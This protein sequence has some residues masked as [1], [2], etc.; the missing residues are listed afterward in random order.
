MC[1]EELIDLIMIMITFTIS[2]YGEESNKCNSLSLSGFKCTKFGSTSSF[3]L[4]RD[5]LRHSSAR[6]NHVNICKDK[7]SASALD[8]YNL[9]IVQQT[10]I[11][12]ALLI[13]NWHHISKDE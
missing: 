7:L 12:K 9:V 2:I 10:I 4:C 6:Q 1:G 3:Y 13:H 11:K 8:Q 5:V